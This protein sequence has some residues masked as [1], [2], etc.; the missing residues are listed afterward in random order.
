MTSSAGRAKS[1]RAGTGG[2]AMAKVVLVGL[3]AGLLG[4]MFGV[5]G[6]L[7]IVP[8]LVFVLGFDHRLAH[9]TSLTAILPIAI[10]SLITYSAADNVDWPAALWLSIGAI[11]GALIGTKLLQVIPR[12]ALALAFVTVLLATA[13]RLVISTDAAGRG[14]LDL[15]A[16]AGLVGVGILSGTLAGLL[17]VGGGIVMVP[18]MIVLFGIPP[19]VAKGTS[20]AVIIPT[21]L[22]GTWRNRANRNTDLRIGLLVG[23]SGVVSAVLGAIIA[24]QMGPALSNTLFAALLV[25]VIV[26]QL[27]S[28]PSDPV[29]AP[30]ATPT[31]NSH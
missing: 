29:P 5:G 2:P 19:V 28:L 7:L 24:D 13:V 11:G 21:S 26:R 12:R 27:S 18:A 16:G 17:G 22:M 6:G 4:G 23:A 20:V 30:A 31:E 3:A 14:P 15:L 10:A 8:A 1:A 9:G 25:V